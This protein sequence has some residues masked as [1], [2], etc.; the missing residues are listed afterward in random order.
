MSNAFEIGLVMA[1]A[2]SAG[3]YTAGVMDF[4]IQALDEWYK[5]EN[6]KQ[7]N[8]STPPHDVKLKVMAG[9]SAGSITA[10]IAIGALASKFPPVTTI[11]GFADTGN[12]LFDSWVNHIDIKN[13][14]T[15][16][17]L[18]REGDRVVSLLDSTVLTEIAD[19]ALDIVPTG[20]ARPYVS[21]VLQ[22]ITTVTN[23]RGVPYNIPLKGEQRG[24]HDIFLHADYVQFAVSDGGK[25][26]DP[27]ALPLDWQKQATFKDNWELLKLAALASGAFPVGLA[28]RKLSYDFAKLG[29]DIYQERPWP[30]PT[31]GKKN[32]EGECQCIEL[33]KITPF[34][35]AGKRPDEYGF[36]CVDGGL[37]NNEPL[38]LARQILAGEDERNPRTADSATRA[39]IM[40]DPFPSTD[41]DGDNNFAPAGV[42]ARAPEKDL[43]GIILG[44]FG[45]LKDQARFK[46]DELELAQD[47]TVFSRFLIGPTRYLPDNKLAKHPIACGVLGGFGGFL[48]RDFRVHDFFLG[49]RNCQR[50]LQSYFV[51]AENNPLFSDWDSTLRAQYRRSAEGVSFLPVI[52][53]L[54]TAAVESEQLPWPTYPKSELDNLKE[55]IGNRY[56]IVSERL[57]EYYFR[58][59]SWLVRQ[60]A[61]LIVGRKR[62]DVVDFALSRIESDLRR[63]DLLH[64]VDAK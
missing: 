23:L 4:L 47:P 30:I 59:K 44:M 12:K 56:D 49:R 50:F 43:V 32:D 2:I 5:P 61:K 63:F 18:N 14:L 64:W 16:R 9:A 20:K 3:A 6:W 55:M 29:R 46:P 39:V 45:A 58:Q 26:T 53:L 1:G 54:G 25:T 21:D 13:L 8:G 36:L 38:E 28:P 10:A 7:R 15:A 62:V 34:W 17:D 24:G 27:R 33:K 37:M 19:N 22:V 52:P 11:G 40:I 48:S 57:V 42:D 41:P 51:L 35:P 60:G 31:G